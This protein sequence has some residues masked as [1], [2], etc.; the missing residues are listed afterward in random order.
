[1]SYDQ[2]DRNL[3]A[4]IREVES[5]DSLTPMQRA[6]Q[7]AMLEKEAREFLRDEE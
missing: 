5:D 6:K 2:I 4:A 1:M 3:Q 7:I